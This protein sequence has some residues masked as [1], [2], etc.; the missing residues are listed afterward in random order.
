MISHLSFVTINPVCVIYP[1][2][3]VQLKKI[4]LFTPEMYYRY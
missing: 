1:N 3:Y 2:G 4:L